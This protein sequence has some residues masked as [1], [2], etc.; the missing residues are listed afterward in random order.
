M[1][2]SIRDLL[3]LTAIVALGVG[4][5]LDRSSLLQGFSLR[6][7]EWDRERREL[8]VAVEKAFQ[9]EDE[10]RRR[11]DK[12][13]ESNERTPEEQ[14]ARLRRFIEGARAV[15]DTFPTADEVIKQLRNPG[16]P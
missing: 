9:R 15:D 11:L 2:F 16:V 13:V 1:R 12:L 7:E 6:A 3:L 8:E 10:L 4:W 14:E 5:W